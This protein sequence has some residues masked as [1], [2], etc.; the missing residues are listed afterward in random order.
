M[1]I[2]DFN[3]LKEACKAAC[4]ERRACSESYRMMLLSNNVSEMMATWRKYWEDITEGK[5][6]DIIM[7]RLSEYYPSLK[8]DMNAAGIYL[9]ECPMSAQEFVKV[10]ITTT[11]DTVHIYGY[12]QA[13]VMGEC[14]VVCHNHSRIQN[15]SYNATIELHDWSAG[16][17][18][19]G[20]VVAYDQTRLR[21][22]CDAELNGNVECTAIGMK[23]KLTAYK[24]VYAY[25]DTQVYSQSAVNRNM[26]MGKE[27]ILVISNNADITGNE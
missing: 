13:Y 5:F 3:D 2:M 9:N 17:I 10:I 21:C 4:H 11:T 22:A 16:E 20:K 6:S 14:K 1:T 26:V 25:G 24:K 12:A 18:Y 23:L 7:S 19:G 15:K 8:T 27:A